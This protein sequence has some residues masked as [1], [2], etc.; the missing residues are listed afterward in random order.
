MLKC[1]GCRFTAREG[2][3]IAVL[4]DCPSAAWIDCE[5]YGPHSV[6]IHWRP[7]ADGY[8]TVEQ[9]TALSRVFV[10]S[11]RFTS[12][13]N[14]VLSENAIAND[15]LFESRPEA[16]A[17]DSSPQQKNPVLKM[18][19]ER[20][21]ILSGDALINIEA[22]DLVSVL[23]LS[24]GLL[25][26]GQE[27]TLPE[28]FLTQSAFDDEDILQFEINGLSSWLQLPTVSETRST[29]AQRLE[30]IVAESV[31]DDV[32]ENPEDFRRVIRLFHRSSGIRT[33]G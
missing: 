27:N 18:A 33:A 14:I 3:S 16:K 11:P 12:S 30:S 15:F 1:S 20:N 23:D 5:L 29:T 21:L 2:A 26:Q 25:W 31:F 10:A 8:L 17:P 22:D 9:S 7:S 13:A 32:L 24:R 6:A 28:T 19:V 4:E